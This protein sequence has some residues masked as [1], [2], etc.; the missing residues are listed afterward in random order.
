MTTLGILA[1]A[2]LANF[3][4]NTKNAEATWYAMDFINQDFWESDPEDINIITAMYGDGEN[5]ETSP[6]T[7]YR[8]GI[9]CNIEEDDIIEIDSTNY[10]QLHTM[11][12]NKIYLV[13]SGSYPLLNDN[14]DI[15]LENCSA[16]VG[17]GDVIFVKHDNF[18]AINMPGVSNVIIDNIKVDGNGFENQGIKLT[19]SNNNTINNVEVLGNTYTNAIGIHLDNSNYNTIHNAR[20][21][22]NEDAGIY[23]IGSNSNYVYDS[24]IY[25]NTGLY[26]IQI[27]S[28]SYYNTI[29]NCHIFNNVIGIFLA[30]TQTINNSQIYNNHAGIYDTNWTSVLN[31]S[32]I[33]NNIEGGFIGLINNSDFFNNNT[34][35]EIYTVTTGYGKIRFFDNSLESLSGFVLGS[36]HSIFSG[37]IIETGSEQMSKYR[38]T[39][40]VNSLGQKLLEGVDRSTLRGTGYWASSEPT[41]Y[42][43]GKKILKQMQPVRYNSSGNLELF[44]DV[45]YDYDTNEYIAAVNME[46]SEDEENLVDYYYGDG[47]EFTLNWEEN[48]CSLGAFTVEHIDSANIENKLIDNDP[49]GHTIYVLEDIDEQI[50]GGDNINISDNCIAVVGENTTGTYLYGQ[51]YGNT[52][53]G[54]INLEGQE[55]IILDQLS[56]NARYHDYGIYLSKTGSDSANNN[57]ISSTEIFYANEDGIKLGSLSQYNTIRNAQLYNNGQHGIN[58]LHAGKYNIINNSLSYNNTGYGIYFGNLSKYNTINNS[59]FFNNGL[60][61]IFTDFNTE[62]NIINNVHSYNNAG[63]GLKLKR[64]S[65]NV[66]NDM[67]IYNNNTG[68]HIDD[69]SCVNNTYSSTLKL[70]DNNIDLVGT[71]G[72]DSY[73]NK[74]S[75]GSPLFRQAIDVDTGA[76]S[77]GCTRNTNPRRYIGS[78]EM[79][80][81]DETG[82]NLT[83]NNLNVWLIGSRDNRMSDYLFGQ[84][85]SKQKAPVGYTGTTIE[86]LGTQYDSGKYIGEI[87]PIIW[88]DPGTISITYASGSTDLNTGTV[89]DI[90]VSYSTGMINHN[91]DI[92]LTELY[93]SNATGYVAINMGGGL[94]NMGTGDTDIDWQDIEDVKLMITT[95]T[96]YYETV[97]GTI[98]IGT[99]DYGYSTGSFELKTLPDPTPPTITWNNNISTGGIREGSSNDWQANVTGIYTTNAFANYVTGASDC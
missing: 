36:T 99:D 59:Q 81:N 83:G 31:N 45:V 43:F 46:L 44:G 96:G 72:Y 56:I 97:S 62:Q 68:I 22:D 19:D 6:Y 73:L 75:F 86:L 16:I 94:L 25:N 3:G 42:I 32:Q 95:S 88:T 9:D 87:N 57:T 14:Y 70:F 24:Q 23:M 7:R 74:T 55:N 71:N 8:T 67:Y 29:N 65:G 77:L 89:Y 47:S 58:I 64:S 79:R 11:Q 4:I 63:Y 76:E 92:I 54:I 26:G 34:G 66:L 80:S 1:L 82:C 49:I 13:E 17:E 28:N 2:L 5:P 12:P 39:N 50:Y 20:V 84:N 35:L 85:I 33:Y 40:P 18:I 15:N 78:S 21:H 52:S 53:G 38:I 51:L 41:K 27:E 30:Q 10:T 91:Y 93:P 69:T 98:Y 61:G 60:G 48:N 90:Q 37:G